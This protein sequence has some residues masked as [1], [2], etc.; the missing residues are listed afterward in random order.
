MKLAEARGEFDFE[1]NQIKIESG[2]ASS[3]TENGINPFMSATTSHLLS[4][5]KEVGFSVYYTF[6]LNFYKTHFF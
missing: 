2:N 4:Q 6:E 5:V 3:D 1:T